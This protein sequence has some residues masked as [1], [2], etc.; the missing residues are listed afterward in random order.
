MSPFVLGEI[1]WVFVNTLTAMASVLFKVVKIC[2]SQFK[3]NFLKNQSVFLNF[4]FNVW[5]LQEILNSRKKNMMVPANL[6]PKLQTLNNLVR[7]LSKKRSFRTR[8]YSEHVK[9]SLK[10]CEMCMRKV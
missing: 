7:P 3:C 8:F 1:L 2:N 9:A 5:I 10:A 6:L 4:L